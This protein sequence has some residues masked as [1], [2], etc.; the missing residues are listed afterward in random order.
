MND[1][2]QDRTVV[3]E[4][5]Y[6]EFSD[7]V[8]ELYEAGRLDQEARQRLRDMAAQSNDLR[9]FKARLH[10]GGPRM[11]GPTEYRYLSSTVD[12]PEGQRPE[13]WQQSESYVRAFGID[14][15]A[16]LT[17]VQQQ[18]RDRQLQDAPSYRR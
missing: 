11:M 7:R 15:Y 4:L 14:R 6:L 5:E 18:E 12:T 17:G 9:E 10:Y 1:Q 8:T 16:T 13:S 3:E 2:Y